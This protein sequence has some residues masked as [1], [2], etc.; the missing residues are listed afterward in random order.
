MIIEGKTLRIYELIL[1]TL[2]A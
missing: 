2:A 1:K